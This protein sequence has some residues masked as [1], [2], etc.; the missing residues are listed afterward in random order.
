MVP[1]RTVVERGRVLG[2]DEPAVATAFDGVARRLLAKLPTADW[3]KRD[4][5][6]ISP[7]SLPRWA[8]DDA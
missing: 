5:E 7:A 2:A 1:G 3:S 6:Q 8:D 4:L